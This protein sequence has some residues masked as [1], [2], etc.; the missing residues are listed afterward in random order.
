MF[1][2]AATFAPEAAMKPEEP[3]RARQLLRRLR[4]PPFDQGREGRPQIVMVS[5]TFVQSRQNVRSRFE[6]SVRPFRQ[7]EKVL[8]MGQPQRFFVAARARLL[9]GKLADGLQHGE[10]RFSR[11]SVDR[12][13]QILVDKRRQTLEQVHARR[14]TEH[15]LGGGERPPAGKDGQSAEQ[16][17]LRRSEKVVAPGDGLSQRALPSGNVARAVGKERQTSVETVENCLWRQEFYPGRREFDRQ[18]QSVHS[19]ADGGD[20]RGIGLG[21]PE[22]VP[23]HGGPLEEKGDR[24]IVGQRRRVAGALRRG[25]RQRADKNFMFDLDM[26]P[27]PTGRQEGQTWRRGDEPGE[28]GRGGDNLLAVIE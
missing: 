28:R 3:E 15:G 21:Q 17:L 2:P 26:Q 4:L 14:R 27:F 13:D 10:S 8:G 16:R 24:R 1:E 25:R 6:F 23:A 5:F 20:G 22:I 7:C 18:R 12:D 19:P 11:R 9:G